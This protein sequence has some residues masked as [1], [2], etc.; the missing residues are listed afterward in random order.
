[1]RQ[2]IFA[3]WDSISQDATARKEE[4]MTVLI[5]SCR[6]CLYSNYRIRSPLVMA[7]AASD[8]APGARMK[9]CYP[10]ATRVQT[11]GAIPR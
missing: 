9:C 6:G 11:R 1:M 8:I 5:T 7:R 10:G 2:I 4:Y 3:P